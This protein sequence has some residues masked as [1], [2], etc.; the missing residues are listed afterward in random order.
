MPSRRALPHA[1]Q[2]IAET[3]IPSLVQSRR[4]RLFSSS[5]WGFT[6]IGDQKQTIIHAHT[7]PGKIAKP[8]YTV[9]AILTRPHT[10]TAVRVSKQQTP[11]PR[12]SDTQLRATHPLLV[13]SL[14]CLEMRRAQAKTLASTF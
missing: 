6:L 13:L 5:H 12:A 14:G 1:F 9:N 10:L 7:S 4:Q 2:P 3:N 11:Q 8:S